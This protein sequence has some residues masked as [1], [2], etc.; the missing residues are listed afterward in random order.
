[1]S[2]IGWMANDQTPPTPQESESIGES[3]QKSMRGSGYPQPPNLNLVMSSEPVSGEAPPETP[4]PPPP[5][6]PSA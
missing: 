6:P 4:P 3:I 5:P 2:S 1:M